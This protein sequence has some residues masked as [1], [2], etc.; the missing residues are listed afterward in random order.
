MMVAA[1]TAASC[2]DSDDG[3][4][5]PAVPSVVAVISVVDESDSPLNDVTVSYQ[6][7]GGSST[8]AS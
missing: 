6:L 3:D 8:Q 2:G 7:D 5:C 4:V 1:D